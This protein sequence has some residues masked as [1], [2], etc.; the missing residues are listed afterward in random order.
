MTEKSLHEDTI[1]VHDGYDASLHHGSLTVPLY[2]TST[3]S[4]ENAEQGERRF[5][6][7]E[8]GLIYSRLGNPTV[9]LLESRMAALEKGQGALAFGSGMALSLINI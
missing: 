1:V 7:D 6:G 4:F 3:Y 9:Q 2:Q 8:D 5:S